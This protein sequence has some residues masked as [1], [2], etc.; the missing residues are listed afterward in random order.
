MLQAQQILNER[1]KL[2]QQLGNNSGRQTWLAEDLLTQNP[3]IVKLL[4]FSPQM[5]WD[6]FKL[7]EREAQVLQQLNHPRIPRY[8][9]YFSIDKPRGAGLHWFALVQ[10]YIPGNSL[11]NLLDSGKHFTE[12]EVNKIATCLLKILIYLHE[13]NPVVLHRDI[14]PS[15][16]IWGENSEIYLVDFGAV[17]DPSAVEGVTF[18][19]VGTAGY[20][21]L[22]QFYGRTVPASDLYAFGATLIHLLTG[23]PP[24]DLPHQNLRIQFQDIV[25]LDNFF[26]RWIEVLTDPDIQQRFSSA[27]EAL[28]ALEAGKFPQRQQETKLLKIGSR[29]E[30]KKSPNFLTVEILK[31]HISLGGIFAIFWRV[32]ITAGFLPLQMLFLLSVG[33]L[34]MIGLISLPPKSYLFMVFVIFGAIPFMWTII[35]NS[36]ENAKILI[37]LHQVLL[38]NFGYQKLEFKKKDFKITKR[39]VNEHIQINS[40]P[41][42]KEIQVMGAQGIIFEMDE[43]KTYSFGNGLNPS[44]LLS[45]CEEIEEWR[46]QHL[47]KTNNQ[48]N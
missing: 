5:Q 27:R 43:N 1:Y 48:T 21:P 23:I 20:A 6:E 32:L 40:S 11:Q 9:D 42:I 44:E 37:E 29:I 45:L 31:P 18:T 46:L 2:N 14:K 36:A 35:E 13:L 16:I 33:F 17:Q 7:F 30:I 22:E 12:S 41:H 34:M 39:L 10:D 8:Q 3:V 4:A 26:I 38:N 19:V 15:N 25:S 47:K 24:A 28:E